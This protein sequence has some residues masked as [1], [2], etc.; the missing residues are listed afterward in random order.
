MLCFSKE[1]IPG[2][3]PGTQGIKELEVIEQEKIVSTLL[4]FHFLVLLVLILN[5]VANDSMKSSQ[6]GTTKGT[7]KARL[8]SCTQIIVGGIYSRMFC[9]Y[10]KFLTS[11]TLISECPLYPTNSCIVSSIRCSPGQVIPHILPVPP[12]HIAPPLYAPHPHPASGLCPSHM[13]FSVACAQCL[14]SAPACWKPVL[15]LWQATR[16]GN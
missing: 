3:E 13:P 14:C 8:Q 4:V 9:L 16:R 10:I 2:T 5:I 12:S 7:D 6:A 15:S 11:K 1:H